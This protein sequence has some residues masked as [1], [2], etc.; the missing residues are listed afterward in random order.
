MI[1]YLEFVKGLQSKMPCFWKY[2]IPILFFIF[3]ECSLGF[4]GD[5]CKNK[6]SRYCLNNDSCDHISGVCPRGCIDGYN[7]S[8]CNKCKTYRVD[9]VMKFLFSSLR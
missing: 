1:S 2:D 5:K 8:R 4:F 9:T 7:G 6:C 3:V